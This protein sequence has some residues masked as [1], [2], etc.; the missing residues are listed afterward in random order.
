[1]FSVAEVVTLDMASSSVSSPPLQVSL[2][3]QVW[4]LGFLPFTVHGLPDLLLMRSGFE[5]LPSMILPGR[6]AFGE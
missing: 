4:V 2:L 1:M 6:V 5:S 3:L